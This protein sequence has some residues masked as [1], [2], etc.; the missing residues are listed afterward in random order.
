MDQ[1]PKK[2]NHVLRAVV[3]LA[4]IGLAAGRLA[5]DD[6]RDARQ[7][8]ARAVEAHG[9]AAKLAKV[10]AFSWKLTGLAR[11]GNTAR[12]VKGRLTISGLDHMRRE[13]D[14]GQFSALVVIAGQSG[15]RRSGD[16][17][18]ELA[19]SELADEK[20]GVYL[21]F[22]AV[23]LVPLEGPGFKFKSHG[24]ERLGDQPAY[25]L[26]YTGPDGRD[27]T[28]YF[29]Q[30]TNLLKKQIIKAADARGIEHTF[31]TTFDA[32]KDFD[33]IKKATKIDVNRDAKPISAINVTE[34]TVLDHVDPSAFA[35]PKDVRLP[36]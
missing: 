13:Y 35:P 9:G 5:A 27:F 3:I 6:E 31:E 19:G 12:A 21:Q 10:K 18:Q 1:G 25:K 2:I 11:T 22:I 23:T 32:Y 33:G 26:I 14:I 28:C 30:R 7:V 8:L 17:T 34:F 24:E 20:R 29:D 16:R 36:R 4:G 15:W